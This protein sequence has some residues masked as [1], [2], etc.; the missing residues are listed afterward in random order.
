[1]GSLF[2]ISNIIIL[3]F[4]FFLQIWGIC[5]RFIFGRIIRTVD[6]ILFIMPIFIPVKTI[7]KN[8]DGVI[9][10]RGLIVYLKTICVYKILF[11]LNLIICFL[12]FIIWSKGINFVSGM[13]YKK[14]YLFPQ[15]LKYR[16]KVRRPR[17]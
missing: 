10:K 9:N 16:W 14:N 15:K 1:M 2:F 7:R 17:W 4:T 12:F 3:V 6:K 13:V 5:C 8:V 11:L